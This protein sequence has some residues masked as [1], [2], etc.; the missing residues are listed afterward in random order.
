MSSTRRFLLDSN[1]FIDARNRYY[2]FDLCP[3]FWDAL[4]AQHQQHRVISIDKVRAELIEWD[5]DI[6][7]WV[8]KIAPR[9]FFE[10]TTTS[11]V[12]TSYG[13]M[14]AWVQ[15]QTQLKPAAKAEFAKHSIADGWI[16]AHARANKLVVVTHEGHQPDARNRVMIPNLCRAFDVE[17]CNPFEML[18]ELGERFVR[19][20]ALQ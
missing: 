14:Q 12:L 18:L 20:Q 13:T 5:D 15:T 8:T 11:E 16:V 3:G 10:S 17:C 1:V 4:I 6:K 9:S 19:F 7:H 2:A